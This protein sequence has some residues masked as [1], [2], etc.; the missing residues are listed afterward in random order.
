[1]ESN[2]DTPLDKYFD[3]PSALEKCYS[4]LKQRVKQGGLLENLAN[5]L[6]LGESHSLKFRKV[7]FHGKYIRPRLTQL[8]VALKLHR[9]TNYPL[10]LVLK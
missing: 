2:I 7:Y 9:L 8:I 1:M 4:E 6:V 10:G 5:V 3:D